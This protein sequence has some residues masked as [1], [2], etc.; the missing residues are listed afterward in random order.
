[1]VLGLTGPSRVE[2]TPGDALLVNGEHSQAALAYRE[3]I[4][5]RPACL[6]AWAGYALAQQ[7]SD[8]PVSRV[9]RICPEVV[10]AVH[11]LLGDDAPDL[12]NLASWLAPVGV[13]E[14]EFG[15]TQYG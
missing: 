11:S 7:A 12:L 10:Y 4:Q 13:A 9:L 1:M 15:H 8:D 5:E 6:D 14:M 2:P 3:Q